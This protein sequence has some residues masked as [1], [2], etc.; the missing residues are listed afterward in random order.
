[1]ENIRQ[2]RCTGEQPK[3]RTWGKTRT[4]TGAAVTDRQIA[5]PPSPV[6]RESCTEVRA[7][8]APAISR[9][10]DQL[11]TI[12]RRL[13]NST[14]SGLQCWVI[15]NSTGGK[16]YVA[17]TWKIPFDSLNRVFLIL[18]EN[19]CCRH[20]YLT[21]V[22]FFCWFVYFFVHQFSSSNPATRKT[23]FPR[24]P[25]C[26]HGFPRQHWGS[27]SSPLGFS[28]PPESQPPDS[29]DVGPEGVP[30][31][32]VNVFVFFLLWLTRPTRTIIKSPAGVD[33]LPVYR[34][35]VWVAL[36]I[37]PVIVRISFRQFFFVGHR[38]ITT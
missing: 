34:L 15:I 32:A 18:N 23:S 10:A 12:L 3:A 19:E 5:T 30:E 8:A 6:F 4:G 31:F 17:H 16:S 21:S 33:C 24:F 29:R 37:F 20:Y 25:S 27:P 11:M 22:V 36:G 2:G 13:Q 7:D 38:L 35:L 1:M 14:E 26:S 9:D 28:V